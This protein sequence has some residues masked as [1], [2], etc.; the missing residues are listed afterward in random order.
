MQCKASGEKLRIARRLALSAAK[1]NVHATVGP[2]QSAWRVLS[3]AL[4]L[5]FGLI[6]LALDVGLRYALRQPTFPPLHTP[7][8]H[9]Y[10][11]SLFLYE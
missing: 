4:Q 10:S 7:N 8:L 2:K 11:L 6:A 1:P 5:A 3:F 9:L